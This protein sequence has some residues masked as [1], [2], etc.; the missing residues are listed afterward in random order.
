MRFHLQNFFPRPQTKSQGMN[1]DKMKLVETKENE[2][3][4]DIRRIVRELCP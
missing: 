2:V 1:L 4:Q 3:V